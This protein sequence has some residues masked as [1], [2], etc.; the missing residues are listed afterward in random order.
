VGQ[1]RFGKP[2]RR[3]FLLEEGELARAFAGL[4]ILRYEEPSPPDGPLMARLLAR[5]RA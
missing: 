5:N 2:K 1:E 4:E 3:R